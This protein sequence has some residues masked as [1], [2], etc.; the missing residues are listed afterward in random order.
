MPKTRK[1]KERQKT[2]S[3]QLRWHFPDLDHGEADGL[4]DPL[5][6]YFEGNHEWYIARE[7]IQNS[8]DARLDYDQPVTVVFEKM[9][10]APKDVPGIGELRAR[11]KACLEQAEESDE[12]T[13]AYFKNALEIMEKKAVP[14]LRVSDFNTLGLDGED[15]DK[16]GRWYRLVKSVGVNRM[17]GVGGGS[18]GIG[19]G[20][21][22]A[23]SA[24]RTVLYSTLNE[25]NEHIF[26]GRTRLITHE[27]EDSERRGT[28]F[29]GID[30]YK[31]VRNPSLIPPSFAR[32]ERGTDVYIVCYN[33][34][35]DD[36]R[37]ELARSVLENFWLAIHSGD[38]EIRLV[39]ESEEIAIR[40]TTLADNLKKYSPDGAFHYYM[41]VVNPT[42]SEEK[43]LPTLGSCKLYVRQ[44]VAYPKDVA[45]MRKPKMVV[46]KRQFR[47]LQDG[48]AGVFVCDDDEGN[49]VLRDMEPPEHDDWKPEL[50]PDRTRANKAATELVDWIRETLREMA[51]VDTGDPEDIPELDRF[52]P[53]E[54]DSLS[55]NS[56]SNMQ[57]SRDAFIEESPEEIGAEKDEV[58]DEVEDFVQR[59]RIAQRTSGS[60]EGSS[61]PRGKEVIDTDGRSG[62]SDKGSSVSRI[63]TTGLRFRII[64]L[65]KKGEETEY[66]LIINPL[67]EQKGAIN[68]VGV[69][70][71]ANY[72]VAVAYA[73]DWEGKKK[74]KIKSSFITDLELR[75]GARQKI[76]I[77]L[78]SN[79]K[80]ALGIE[81][82]EG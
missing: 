7:T 24:I 39:D 10:F 34:W 77:G 19:K 3:G 56:N 18:F 26:Q 59:P 37:M 30:G 66:C 23:A 8:L 27:F 82:Y 51:N 13:K 5:L 28:G 38:L 31:S 43:Q 2:S 9:K 1:I 33:S 20:A 46:R 22:I 41:A 50:H 63:N 68:I 64:A 15:N 80:Y 25:S 57:P 74:Y 36:W 70:D 35:H 49:R 60:E 14:I 79:R 40:T 29:F 6:Q 54:D 67:I 76:K 17:T 11:M 65:P 47:I 16:A 45:L 12:K 72:P 52:L 42:R 53:Y 48:Y 55:Q 4:A 75:K 78:R 21:P 61:G 62:G 58:E 73:Q 32:S 44:D 71:D 81:N 69:G